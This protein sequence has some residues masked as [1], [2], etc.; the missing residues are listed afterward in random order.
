M[1]RKKPFDPFKKENIF[2]KYFKIIFA[3]IFLI[4]FLIVTVSMTKSVYKTIYDAQVRKAIGIT[5]ANTDE[6]VLSIE[7]Q[8]E[9]L[10]VYECDN[11]TVNSRSYIIL[12]GMGDHNRDK[13]LRQRENMRKDPKLKDILIYDYD[14]N[15][16]L[17][18][19]ST[20]FI[21]ITKAFLTKNPADELVIIGTSAGGIVASYSAAE[22]EFSGRLELHTISSPTNGYNVNENF[23]TGMTGFAKEIGLGIKPFS[24]PKE[25]VLIYHHKTVD[26]KELENYCGEYANFCKS[27]DIQSNDIEGSKEFYY[28]GFTHETIMP[29]VIDLI[30]ACRR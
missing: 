14:E 17:E 7:K 1:K 13:F 15:T 27:F 11:T 12:L 24:K 5:E 2:L 22:I 19:I 18:D 29:H 6:P 4:I 10:P 28:P 9:P 8:N 25:N 16:L 26:D 30:V 3:V 23:L 21:Q 20:E